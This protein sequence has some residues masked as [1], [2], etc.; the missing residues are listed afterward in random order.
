MELDFDMVEPWELIYHYSISEIGERTQRGD[1]VFWSKVTVNGTG[2]RYLTS[3]A[4]SN[5][6][7]PLISMLRGFRQ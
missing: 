1:K 3:A 4:K 5:V 2:F 7:I 6:L